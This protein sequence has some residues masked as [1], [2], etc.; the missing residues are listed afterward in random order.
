MQGIAQ[1]VFR[2]TGTTKFSARTNTTRHSIFRRTMG[3]QGY[4]FVTRRFI[5]PA[6]HQ[7][8]KFCADQFKRC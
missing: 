5:T 2:L 1:W 4:M 8:R 6:G 7:H 3:P